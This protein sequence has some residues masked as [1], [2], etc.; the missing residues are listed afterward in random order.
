MA[1]VQPDTLIWPKTH[2]PNGQCQSAL[3]CA[4]TAPPAPPLQ[5]DHHHRACLVRP[6]QQFHRRPTCR[7]NLLMPLEQEKPLHGSP[8]PFFFP[9]CLHAPHHSMVPA[10]ASI[11]SRL[12]RRQSGHAKSA[13]LPPPSH[14]CGQA[15]EVPV[16]PTPFAA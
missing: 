5:P 12:C 4:L 15:G 3:A 16:L 8:L 14:H 6:R 10:S 1:T 13:S 2:R 9:C 11:A 7:P